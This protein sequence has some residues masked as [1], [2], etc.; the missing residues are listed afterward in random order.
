M[1]KGISSIEMEPYAH[2]NVQWCIQMGQ[3]ATSVSDFKTSR[4]KTKIKCFLD[5]L[6]KVK[7]REVW[8]GLGLKLVSPGNGGGTHACRS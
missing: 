2:T 1:Q 3:E 8:G 7:D 5:A 6:G 4:K